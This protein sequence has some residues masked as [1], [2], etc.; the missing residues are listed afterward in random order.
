MKSIKHIIAGFAALYL[1]VAGCTTTAM[2]QDTNSIDTYV[3]IFESR[4]GKL[5]FDHDVPSR[6]SQQLL[7]D[8]MDF[9]RATQSV[10]WVEAAYN[11]YLF[12]TAMGRVGVENLGAMLYDQK[13]HA[14]QEVLTPNQSVVYM[15]DSINLKEV[16]AVVYEV[17]PG[18]INAGFYDEWN[19]AFYDFGMFGPNR[20]K[21]DKLLIVPPAWAGKVPAGHQLVRSNTYKVF[22]IVR[23]PLSKEMPTDRASAL[24]K[25]IKTYP[26]GKPSFQK[27]FVLM[28]DPA[29]GGKE[30]RVNRQHGI[31]YWKQINEIIQ[32]LIVEERDLYALSM[33]REVGI[34]KGKPFKPNERLTKILVAAERVGHSM[35]VNE[36][37]EIR[38]RTPD[39]LSN[40]KLQRL[41]P[42]TKWLNLQLMSDF[43]GQREDNYGAFTA[44]SILWDQVVSAQKVW[45]PR[46]YPPGF[47]QA[48]AGVAKDK[49]G[50]WLFGERH[51]RLRVN[52][53]VPAKHFWS[54]SIYDVA[55]RSFIET[56]QRGVEFNN[57]V[58]DLDYNDDG[59]VDL[60]LGPTPPKGKE[61]NWIKTIP[62]KTWHAYFRWYG[63]TET[64]WDGTWK[65]NDIELIK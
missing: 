11:T 47:G 28:G 6:D 58:S 27:Q 1:M 5:I 21:G 56:D 2:A 9:Q 22:S 13:A 44:R 61:K 18:P 12:K 64:Y 49:D 15:F 65:L 24:L 20:A 35:L 25:Q 26:V 19:R 53:D 52:A 39:K 55:T 46:E 10:F 17:P 42:G 60:Y 7:F 33:L 37:F 14:G 32:D 48:Y 43:E 50:D 31:E 62:G 40:P 41:F 23:V 34:E 57:R 63:P 3:E 8:E 30:F 38:Y 16:G 59:S 36:A 4:I 54:L 51:Y 29:K 45:T